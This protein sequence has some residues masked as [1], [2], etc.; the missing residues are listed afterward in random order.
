MFKPAL[1]SRILKRKT[2]LK[3]GDVLRT[4]YAEDLR[5]K[6]V[7]WIRGKG[8]IV[9]AARSAQGM[10]TGEVELQIGIGYGLTYL[11]G[12]YRADNPER[13]WSVIKEGSYGG[14]HVMLLITS[15]K[16]GKVKENRYAIIANGETVT[17][18]SYYE[19]AEQAYKRIIDGYASR[20]DG[21]DCGRVE[22]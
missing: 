18:A 12:Y 1:E 8:A 19:D 3:V 13:V 20:T 6:D 21:P 10:S 22:E 9:K 11:R 14:H 16:V 17:Q 15:Q 2:D 5:I 7:E 4:H